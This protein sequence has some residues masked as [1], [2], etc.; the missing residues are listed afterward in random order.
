MKAC[1]RPT[2][3]PNSSRPSKAM[4]NF[5][6]CKFSTSVSVMPRSTKYCV[7]R[8]ASAPKSCATQRRLMPAA[9]RLRTVLCVGKQ[10]RTRCRGVQ[11]HDKRNRN[12]VGH[13]VLD[14]LSELLELA[15]KVPQVHGLAQAGRALRMHACT[16][17]CKQRC[18]RRSQVQSSPE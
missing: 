16:H 1:Q 4:I 18:N 12:I 17:V 14:F 15:A 10:C 11:R 13:L 3:T 5:W 7:R 2:L 8:S 6:L 9:A